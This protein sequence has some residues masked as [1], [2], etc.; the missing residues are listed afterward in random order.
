MPGLIRNVGHRGRLKRKRQARRQDGEEIKQTRGMRWNKIGNA[1]DGS[2]VRTHQIWNTNACQQT[3]LEPEAIY[4]WISC[5]WDSFILYYR[6][7][8]CSFI[9][10]YIERRLIEMQRQT[11]PN[12]IDNTI[13][14]CAE[15]QTEWFY[16]VGLTTSQPTIVHLQFPEY[17]INV[18][19]FVIC[20]ASNTTVSSD[21]WTTLS[22]CTVQQ[23]LQ[24]PT[25]NIHKN[26]STNT[27]GTILQK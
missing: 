16:A 18:G 26:W 9:L 7:T 14:F 19:I 10:I 11:Q 6:L 25:A 22:H 23:G 15:L 4:G 27:Q 17:Y 13:T 8:H 24:N 2:V 12:L 5:E 21:N 1:V 20:M 3:T